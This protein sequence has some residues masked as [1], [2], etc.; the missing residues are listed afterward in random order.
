MNEL[1]GLLLILELHVVQKDL[2]YM[3]IS[4]WTS[5]KRHV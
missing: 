3:S 2:Q 4:L 1:K 5:A